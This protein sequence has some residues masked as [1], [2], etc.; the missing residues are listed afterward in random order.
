MCTVIVLAG[1]SPSHP[2]VVAANRDELYARPTAGPRVEGRTIVSGV[3]LV[4]G[5]TWMGATA[6]GLIV[7]VT[8]QRTGRP[9]DP[10]RKSRGALVT[11]CLA[12]GTREAALALA[13]ALD[14]ADYN[15]FNLVL[16]DAAGVDVIYAEGG[17]VVRPPGVTVVTNDHTEWAGPVE[18]AAQPW[19]R[20]A[21][22]LAAILA[23]PPICRHSPSYG[24][25]SA[26]I[27]A[28]AP[29]GLAHYLV[30]EQAACKA[31]LVSHRVPA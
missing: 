30:S 18:V 27:A 24:T 1:T 5:G 23:E 10:T 28:V 6:G 19:P 15:P 8:N 17:H 13:L 2:L 12:A 25:R 22:S 3:D 26:T 7:A 31:P 16:A 4:S 14:P 20:L 29:T 11:A 21:T 9:P